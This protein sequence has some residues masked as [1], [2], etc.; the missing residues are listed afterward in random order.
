MNFKPRD[1]VMYR[2]PLRT[3]DSLVFI[4]EIVSVDEA[5]QKA[6]VNFPTLYTSKWIPMA[7]L[8][9]TREHFGQVR[10]QASPAQRTLVKVYPS[11]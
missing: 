10:V 8:Q 4:G 11:V 3:Q 1:Q 2:K 7:D 5:N 9:Q 6:R